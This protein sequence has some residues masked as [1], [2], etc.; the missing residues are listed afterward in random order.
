MVYRVFGLVPYHFH[1]QSVATAWQS[2]LSFAKREKYFLSVKRTWFIGLL[3]F[4][5]YNLVHSSVL[6][7]RLYKSADYSF[8]IFRFWNAI[9]IRICIIIITVESYRHRHIQ[10]EIIKNLHEIDRIFAQTLKLQINYHRLRAAVFVAFAKWMGISAIVVSTLFAASLIEHVANFRL[11]FALY[12]LV[13]KAMLG[14]VYMTYAILI[15]HRIRAIH[16]VLDSDLLLIHESTFALQQLMHL[17]HIFPRIHATIQLINA[18][19]KWSISM[20]FFVNVF[21]FCETTY[22]HLDKAFQHPKHSIEDGLLFSGFAFTFYYVLYFGL[23]I[24]MA[25]SISAEANKIPPKIHRLNLSRTISDEMQEF[26]SEAGVYLL[27]FECE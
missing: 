1:V 25:H 26:V 16:E 22:Y 5:L 21:D 19:F 27:S 20:N 14:S 9:T 12:P 6:W 11:M 18:T 24:Q 7:H 23:I 2:P 3:L 13:K 8:N 10:V 17:L 4:E 15:R